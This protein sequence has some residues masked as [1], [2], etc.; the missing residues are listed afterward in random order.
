MRPRHLPEWPY[1]VTPN[2]SRAKRPRANVLGPGT[3][4]PGQRLSALDRV[5]HAR[6]LL[7]VTG[8]RCDVRTL[9]WVERAVGIVRR[10][11]VAGKAGDVALHPPDRE[12]AAVPRVDLQP[13]PAS[14]LE[15]HAVQERRFQ[16]L[17]A[18]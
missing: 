17:A 16:R 5:H 12:H 18:Q 8:E 13:K 11:P 3:R 14:V 9:D 4:D 1:G 10:A 7:L 2:V 15:V 6:R